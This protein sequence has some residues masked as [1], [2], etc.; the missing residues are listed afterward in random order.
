MITQLASQCPTIP[1]SL[2]D[3][4]ELQH[5]CRK[6]IDEEVY[7]STLRSII[8]LFREIY[9]VLDALDESSNRDELL[10]CIHQIQTWRIPQAHLLVTSRQLP[11]I[12]DSLSPI[13]T[14]RLCLHNC[15]LNKDVHIYLAEKLEHDRKLSRWPPEIREQIVVR[16]VQGEQE[17]YVSL[18]QLAFSLFHLTRT[19]RRVMPG[20]DIRCSLLVPANYRLCWQKVCSRKS[21]EGWEIKT[22]ALSHEYLG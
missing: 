3:L 5:N 21:R 7:L 10:N 14:D 13:I 1:T 6:R 2:A 9:I 4:Y 12:E 19:I 15:S 20:S 16:L 17:M 11:E 8:I 18:Y 22:T